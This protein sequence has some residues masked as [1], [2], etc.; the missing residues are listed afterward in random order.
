ML[1]NLTFSITALFIVL[2]LS[3]CGP[4]KGPVQDGLVVGIEDQPKTLDPRYATDVYGMRIAHHLIFSSLVR[5]GEDLRIM[6]D[7][8][9]RWETPDP[10][11]Y[12][13]HL[14]QGVT[15]HDGRPLTARDVVFT[16]HHLMDPSTQSPFGPNYRDLIT[17]V[18]KVSP[19]IVRFRL[20]RPTASFLTSIIMPILPA[21]LLEGDNKDQFTPRLVGSGPFRFISQTAQAITLDA[22]PGYF[23][24]PPTL[25]R[26]VF[27]IIKD[28]NTRFLK[29]RK[30]E[31]DLLINALP[32]ERIADF[33]KSPLNENY[34]VI[35]GPGISYNYLAFNLIDSL[36]AN[37]LVRQA[38]AHALNVDEIITHRLAG[39]AERALGLL[40]P[41]NWYHN[42]EIAIPPNNPT[43]ARALLKEAGFSDPDGDGPK[44]AITLELKTS[45][46]AQSV[47]IARILQAQLAQAG[48][49]VE[50][51]SYEWGT[52][53]GDIQ[54]G[55]FQLTL[56][57]WVG[58]TE[59]DFYYDIFHSSQVPPGGRNRGH[60]RN[61]EM[62]RLVEEGRT[63]M[64]QDQRRKIYSGVQ[65]L[66][67]SDLPY[68]NLWH[69]NTVS[70]V[71][72]RVQG[73]KQHP[74][75]SFFSFQH[76][77][78]QPS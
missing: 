46:N 7:L 24:G 42:P 78:L 39:H 23:D 15:F 60:Y 43:K 73:Y 77:T 51:K 25:P 68:V 2:G 35:E 9:E 65:Q 22:Y 20:Q 28:N 56:M 74:M 45:N 58:V 6:G 50:I 21:H 11:T 32:P 59:P 3:A 37:L 67:A 64:N 71:H 52:F 14:R 13:F 49:G 44:P 47:A 55:N 72:K 19:L 41:V 1:R 36:A 5:H 31:L 76:I 75:G 54:A 33:A 8:A 17:A 66:A 18:E 27:A 62:D 48:I 38:V 12:L 4:T 16:F 40:S 70:I 61:L 26:V 34:T 10:T 30:G 69:L 29:A 63:A 57:R 53:Y